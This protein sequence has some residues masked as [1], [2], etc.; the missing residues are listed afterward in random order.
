MV[1]IAGIRTLC[2]WLPNGNQEPCSALPSRTD[3]ILLV[4]VMAVQRKPIPPAWHHQSR[5]PILLQHFFHPVTSRACHVPATRRGRH[6]SWAGIQVTA[7]NVIPAASPQLMYSESAADVL[8]DARCCSARFGLSGTLRALRDVLRERRRAQQGAPLGAPDRRT[9]MVAG[10]SDSASARDALCA[11]LDGP[12]CNAGV[13]GAQVRP[14]V[15]PGYTRVLLCSIV[16]E[17]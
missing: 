17:N 6:T 7:A 2:V 16:L 3:C 4:S 5:P 15:V 8:S 9:D 1:T 10:P 14:L 11:A 12:S 13:V